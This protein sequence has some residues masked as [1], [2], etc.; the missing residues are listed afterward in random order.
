MN[1]SLTTAFTQIRTNPSLLRRSLPLMLA[2]LQSQANSASQG[3]GNKVTDQEASFADVLESN[4]ILFQPKSSPFPTVAGIYYYYQAN[5]SQQSI[6]FRVFETDG[7]II[8]RKV[9][10]D[11]KHTTSEVFFLNDG[12]FHKDVVYVVTWTRRTS[13][14]KKRP[15]TS[16]PATFIALGQNIPSSKEAAMMAELLA[17]KQKYNT[18]F[19]GVESLC[20]YIRFANRYKCDRFTPTATEQC[21]A[22]VNTYLHSSSSSSDSSSVSTSA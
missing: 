12:W 10:L 2:K 9:D 19:K 22:A 6:D 15:I 4:G 14:P 16:E 20:T 5:G 1:A 21:Y 11:L 8:L 17:I 3:T 13:D 18:E 7:K